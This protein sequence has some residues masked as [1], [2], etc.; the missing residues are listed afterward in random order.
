M[1]NTMFIV[2]VIIFALMSLP[3]FAEKPPVEIS[4]PK[5]QE[6]V[7]KYYAMIVSKKYYR[8]IK[9]F[10]NLNPDDTAYKVAS[11]SWKLA[12]QKASDG[13]KLVWP[14]KISFVVAGRFDGK[15]RDIKKVEVGVKIYRKDNRNRVYA[16]FPKYLHDNAE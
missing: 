15:W 2:A 1:R 3:A 14:M 12:E 7:A 8:E 16:T 9:E 10:D 13:D 4:S 6:D 5:Y 11:L